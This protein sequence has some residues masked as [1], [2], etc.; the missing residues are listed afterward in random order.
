MM[1]KCFLFEI[2][3][4]YN[5]PNY[6]VG[7][8]EVLQY[9]CTQNDNM[10][11]KIVQHNNSYMHVMKQWFTLRFSWGR[12]YLGFT[13]YITGCT[14]NFRVV[15]KTAYFNFQCIFSV[16]RIKSRWLRIPFEELHPKLKG[17]ERINAESELREAMQHSHRSLPFVTSS[18]HRAI[19]GRLDDPDFIE[20]TELLDAE[21]NKLKEKVDHRAQNM[22]SLM[23]FCAKMVIDTSKVR[24]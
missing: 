11:F 3:K 22:F 18:V 9:T 19:A 10:C 17:L 12:A 4:K 6:Q 7:M 5:V 1:F 15:K 8:F 16:N 13:M 23:L 20:I 2:S 21:C 14:T 24:K